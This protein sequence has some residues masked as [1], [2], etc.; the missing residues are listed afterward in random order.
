MRN[1]SAKYL[2]KQSRGENETNW[3]EICGSNIYQY[4][5]FLNIYNK[6]MFS[7]TIWNLQTKL[8]SVSLQKVDQHTA[9]SG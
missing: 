8:F 1:E 5:Y 6:D 9:V 2:N 4:Q 3:K 7:S